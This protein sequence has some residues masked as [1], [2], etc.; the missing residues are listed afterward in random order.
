M[1]LGQAKAVIFFILVVGIALIQL[2]FTSRRETQ[3]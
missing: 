1:G 2:R 3:A